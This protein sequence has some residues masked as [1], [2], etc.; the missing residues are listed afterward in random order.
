MFPVHGYKVES[1]TNVRA[2]RMQPLQHVQVSARH[3]V[4]NGLIGHEVGLKVRRLCQPLHNGELPCLARGRHSSCKL[5]LTE[6]RIAL[7]ACIR[8]VVVARNNPLQ[9]MHQAGGTC[10]HVQED[11]DCGDHVG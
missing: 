8:M 3:R 4:A 2:V 5:D 11:I 7:H 10:E 1:P 6:E 9:E